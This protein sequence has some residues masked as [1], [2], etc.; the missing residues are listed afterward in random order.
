MSADCIST[1]HRAL[2]D[3]QLPGPV[4]DQASLL[5][6]G[7]DRK[8]A[9]MAASLPSPPPLFLLCVPVRGPAPGTW[10]MS[11]RK[12]SGLFRSLVLNDVKAHLGVCFF[13]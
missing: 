8:T 10:R 13:L 5:D 11:F 1:A 4:Q 12:G 3:Q 9:S 2:P 6:L 7:L